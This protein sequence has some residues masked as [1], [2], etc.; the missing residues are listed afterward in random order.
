[1]ASKEEHTAEGTEIRMNTVEKENKFTQCSVILTL[2]SRTVIGDYFILTYE[3]LTLRYF[4]PRTFLKPT[5]KGKEN[6][7]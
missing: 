4:G 3:I 7:A 5:Q 1:M 6:T 2:S